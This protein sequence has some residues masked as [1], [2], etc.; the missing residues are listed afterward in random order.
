[1]RAS[2]IISVLWVLFSAACVD[3]LSYEINKE[4]NFG[5]SID[6]YIAD[7]PGPYE[8]RINSIFDIESK[9]SMRMPV[10]VRSLIISDDKGNAETLKEI[11]AGVYQ[12]DP[13]GIR[14]VAGGAYKMRVELLDGRIYESLPDTILSATGSLDS[15]Y[16]AFHETYNSIGEKQYYFDLLFDASCNEK[17]NNHFLWTFHG[18]F[19]C[20]TH[21]E[22]YPVPPSP[23]SQCFWLNELTIPSKCNYLPPCS[24]YRNVSP[25]ILVPVFVK[26]YDC[27]C[28]TCWY[29]LFNPSPILSDELTGGKVTGAKAVTIPLNQ[30]TL[31]HKIRLDLS[32]MSLMR[33]TFRFWKAMRDQKTAT[34]NLFQPVSGKIPSNFIQVSGT[35]IPIQG[36]FFATSISRRVE[37]LDRF[38]LPPNLVYAVSLD[39]PIY[40]DDCRKLFPNST[41]IKPPFW[42]D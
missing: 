31:E 34:G 33:N 22:L 14:G 21:P 3:R 17:V 13:A 4:V 23:R 41:N 28:C 40:P 12:T 9:E 39:E 29:N 37:Y 20:E 6:G 5:I 42:K 19:Q 11:E 30:W 1:M 26:K 24:G 27:T 32:Q 25:D 36:L 38:H 16:F 10:S 18:T 15:L 2:F 35:S 7:Q 8:I